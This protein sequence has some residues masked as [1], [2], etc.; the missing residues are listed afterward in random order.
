MEIR[1]ADTNFESGI[2]TAVDEITRRE[3][4]EKSAKGRDLTLKHN[5]KQRNG[6]V[7]MFASSFFGEEKCTS[8]ILVA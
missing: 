7:P 3:G 6:R 8:P 4:G 5:S 1:S 2:F